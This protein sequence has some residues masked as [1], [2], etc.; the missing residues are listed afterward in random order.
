MNVT[1]PIREMAARQWRKAQGLGGHWWDP[2][3]GRAAARLEG[4]GLPACQ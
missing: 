3:P 4:R 2:W 1:D